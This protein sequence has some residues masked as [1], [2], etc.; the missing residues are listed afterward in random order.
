MKKW[1]ETRVNLG[2][3][4]EGETVRFEFHTEAPLKV[5]EFQKGCGTCTTIESFDGNILKVKYKAEVV[6]P[7]VEGDWTPTKYIKVL[8]EDG[9]QE[10]LYFIAKIK[11]K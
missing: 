5:K 3:L 7:Q 11:R 2:V 10:Q 9:T 8:Y 4:I 6:P 1:K